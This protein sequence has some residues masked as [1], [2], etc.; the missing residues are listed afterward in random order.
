MQLLQ[1]HNTE[2]G[3]LWDGNCSFSFSCCCW[4][5]SLLLQHLTSPA[6]Q[7]P[8]RPHFHPSLPTLMGP[9]SSP[10]AS[11]SGCVGN[12]GTISASITVSTNSAPPHGPNA[13]IWSCRHDAFHTTSTSQQSTACTASECE[14]CELVAIAFLQCPAGLK[15]LHSKYTDVPSTSVV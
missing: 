5:C 12:S 14:G 8:C 3:S 9:N 10:L 2:S 7:D 6:P 4:F 1:R 13:A 15:D 11:V